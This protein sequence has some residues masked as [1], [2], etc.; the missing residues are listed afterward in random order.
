MCLCAGKFVYISKF[1]SST[2]NVLGSVSAAHRMSEW[3]KM[4]KRVSPLNKHGS[5]KLAVD[6]DVDVD[7]DA[8]VC[9]RVPA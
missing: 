5:D 6:V 1:L 2:W 8:N 3:K 9:V 7:E 4:A